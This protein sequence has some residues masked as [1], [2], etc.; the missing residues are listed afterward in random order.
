MRECRQCGGEIEAAFRFCPWCAALQ[1]SKLVEFFRAHPLI[2]GDGALRVSRYI[3]T[4]EEE[5]H[6]RFS[7]WNPNGEAQAAVSLDDSEADRLGHFLLDTGRQRSRGRGRRLIDDAV[8]AI[9]G[10]GRPGRARPSRT[11]VDEPVRDSET[12]ST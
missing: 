12:T 1:R 5:R 8:G 6:V 3:G 2:R 4:A 10:H 7:V 9:R 11:M